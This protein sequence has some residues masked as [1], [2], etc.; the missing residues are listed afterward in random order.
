MKT[1]YFATKVLTLLL[2]TGYFQPV[3][4]LDYYWVGGTGN[5]SD[6]NNHWATNSGGSV[7]QTQVPTSTDNVFFDA[8]SFGSSGQ[9]VSIDTT[10][11]HCNNMDWSG[12]TNS[13]T[14]TNSSSANIIKVY[15][16]LTL[17]PS[18]SFSFNG[19]LSLEALNI[20]NTILSAGNTLPCQIDFNG[21]GGGWTLQDPFSTTGEIFLNF[22][23][24]NTNDQDITC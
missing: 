20:G 16:S 3:Q 10:I 7:F 1:I 23:T 2:L 14:L 5:W 11:V 24:L 15:G 18:M 22:G 4:A 21:I 9:S 12:V 19:I 13:P 8:N 17:D 6:Y